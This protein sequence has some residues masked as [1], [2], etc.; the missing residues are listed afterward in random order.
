MPTKTYESKN[1][2]FIISAIVN[3]F[4]ID[5]HKI[6]IKEQWGWNFIL[7]NEDKQQEWNNSLIEH[8]FIEYEICHFTEDAEKIIIHL[9]KYGFE[10][11]GL[12]KITKKSAEEVANDIKEKSGTNKEIYIYSEISEG[13][14]ELSGYA[15]ILL[16]PEKKSFLKRI[17][18]KRTE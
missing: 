17:F 12:G 4:V 3:K 13:F 16:Y 6:S 9:N 10:D 8:K 15:E 14:D 11:A 2:K 18:R 7:F 1:R 5:V